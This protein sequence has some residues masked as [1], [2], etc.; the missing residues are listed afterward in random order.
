[1]PPSALTRALMRSACAW[2]RR[3]SLTA[4]SRRSSNAPCSAALRSSGLTFSRLAALS[5]SALRS[6]EGELCVAANAMPPPAS[7]VRPAAVMA[8]LRLMVCFTWVP[9]SDLRD[10]PQ[11]TTGSYDD[12]KSRDAVAYAALHRH[13]SVPRRGARAVRR[14]QPPAPEGVHAR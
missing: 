14:D 9:S 7:T 13:Q 11:D 12:R 1:M 3:P 8:T 5:S 4:W 10:E 2:V 6:C